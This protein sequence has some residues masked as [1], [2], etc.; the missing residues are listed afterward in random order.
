MTTIFE[1]EAIRSKF[2]ALISQMRFVLFRSAYSA[3]M[4]ESRDCS[5]G[6]CAPEGDAPFPT[7][8]VFTTTARHIRS[9]VPLEEIHDGDMFIG[10]NPY[11]T[12]IQHTPDILVM[13]PVF[14]DGRLVAFCGS[15]AHKSDIGGAVPGSIYSGA[16]ELYQEGLVLPVMKYY[17]KG[18]QVRQVE[19]A[20]RANV[21]NPDIVLGD[22]GAQVGATLLAVERTKD[23]VAKHGVETILDAFQELLA[24]PERR[25]RKIVETWPGHVAEAE[26][27][28]DPPPNHDKP[29]RYHVRVTRQG[30]HLTFDFSESDPQVRSPVNVATPYLVGTLCLCVLGTTDPTIHDNAGVARAFS[31]VTKEGTVASPTPPAPTGNT[32]M[33]NPRFIDVVLKA[34]TMLKGYGPIAERGGHGTTAFGWRRGLVEG[35]TYIQYEIHNGSGVGASSWGDGLSSVN[36]QGYA[37]D[38][39][40]LDS[41]GSLDTPVEIL[42]SQYP[43]RVR[44]FELV[45]DSG[46]PGRFRGGVARR[47][48]YEALAPAT[49]NVRHS[50]GFMLPPQG[51]PGGRPGRM[52]K[53]IINADT[54]RAVELQGWRYELGV[55]DTV[56]FEGAGGGGVGNPFE[57]DPEDV[58]TD[59]ADGLISPE[60]ARRDYGVALSSANGQTSVD[61]EET[62]RLRSAV[63]PRAKVRP[64]T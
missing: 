22:L 62:K 48:V 52:G 12:G 45:A 56:T 55:G 61:R 2:E 28:L 7:F 20:I 41:R 51:G 5:F 49:L 19:E 34:L 39:K 10:N 25:I 60:S 50:M 13:A 35:R 33:V 57:K 18:V 17:E 16:T 40:T 4:R 26:A 14:C 31:V 42:E 9:T 29:V 58:L 11:E 53:V 54:P 43:V 36:P 63:S 24:I 38:R 59:V 23:I 37:L 3:L 32:T 44:R 1:I 30:G 46:G 21:R 47:K 6:V 15:V 8:R 64:S 27:L